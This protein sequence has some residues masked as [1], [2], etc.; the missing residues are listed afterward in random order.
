MKNLLLFTALLTFSFGSA[1]ITT[2][3]GTFNKP[4]AG[5]NCF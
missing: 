2:D 5:E 4:S 3:A 1:Q